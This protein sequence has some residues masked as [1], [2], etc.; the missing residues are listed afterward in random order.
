M[1]SEST[2]KESQ[3]KKTSTKKTTTTSSAKKKT[4]TKVAA[5]KKDTAVK[6]KKETAKPAKKTETKT[7]KTT[8]KK[9]A[10]DENKKVVVK[11][12]VKQIAPVEEKK[13][14]PKEMEEAKVVSEKKETQK[15]KQVEKKEIREH[16]GVY[17]FLLST[18]LICLHVMGRFELTIANITVG[19]STLLF[20]TVYFIS[21]IITKKFD[22]KKTIIAILTSSI[23]M[24][25]FVYLSKYLNT[26]VVDYFVIYGEI[27]A[28]I[29][30]QL[31]N[32]LVYYYL[33]VNTDLKS[34]WVY[35]TYLCSI[36]AYYFIAI[37]FSTRIIITDTFWITF[38]CSVVLSAIIAIM[39]AFYDSMIPRGQNI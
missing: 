37:L 33:L 5:T 1:A 34:R 36:M 13:E 24:L 15:P 32:L 10:K 11:E 22:F 35:L 14:K 25:L 21:N 18:V 27:F 6:V 4:T 7:T 28:Y 23:A 17:L 20:P 29:I 26:K 39:Y 8:P 38:F 30:S 19:F 2:K 3:T 16:F 12:P 31:L 9:E